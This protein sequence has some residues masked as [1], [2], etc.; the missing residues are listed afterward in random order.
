[1]NVEKSNSPDKA[2]NI[3]QIDELSETSSR[4]S[5]EVEND[6]KLALPEP[7]YQQ[8]STEGGRRESAILTQKTFRGITKLMAEGNYLKA[9]APDL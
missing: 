6:E 2:F 8:E 4:Y 5:K 3:N 7:V 9:L 1:M